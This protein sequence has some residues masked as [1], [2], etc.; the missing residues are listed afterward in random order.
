MNTHGQKPHVPLPK[1]VRNARKQKV[2]LS[3]I[4][5]LTL[6]AL[7]QRPAADVAQ[8]KVNLWGINYQKPIISNLRPAVYAVPRKENLCRLISTNMDL[9]AMQN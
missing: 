5:G 9:S 8:Q 6:L 1:L 7:L 4:R 2:N 3:G